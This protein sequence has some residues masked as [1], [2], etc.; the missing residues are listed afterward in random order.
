ML[1]D[2]YAYKPK[3]LSNLFYQI[4]KS[5]GSK[6]PSYLTKHHVVRTYGVVEV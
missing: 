1:T 6:Y 3:K 4:M 5:E 2:A